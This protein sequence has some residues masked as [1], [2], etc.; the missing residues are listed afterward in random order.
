MGEFRS[1]TEKSQRQAPRAAEQADGKQVRI[2]AH[3]W[4]GRNPVFRPRHATRVVT[5]PAAIDTSSDGIY[6]AI[7]SPTVRIA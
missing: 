3:W 5:M 6:D 2:T 1:A 4:T 7:P